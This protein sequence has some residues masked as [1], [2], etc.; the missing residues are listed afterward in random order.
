MADKEELEVKLQEIKQ[1]EENLKFQLEMI[2]EKADTVERML[3][4]EIHRLSCRY[5]HEDQCMWYEETHRPY[6]W[7][8]GAHKHYLQKAQATIKLLPEKTIP[9]LMEIVRAII[10]PHY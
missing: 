4:V 10:Q 1:E 7:T 6:P 5:S 3:A 9:E 8:E 2:K